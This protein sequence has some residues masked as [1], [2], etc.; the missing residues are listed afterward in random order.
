MCRA[1]WPSKVY[2]M[3]AKAAEAVNKAFLAIVNKS[4]AQTPLFVIKDQTIAVNMIK[5]IS[6]QLPAL[7]G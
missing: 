5:A 2:I 4:T 3:E 6:A 7:L 1:S